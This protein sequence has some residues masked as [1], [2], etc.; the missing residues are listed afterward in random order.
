MGKMSFYKVPL[1]LDKKQDT[2]ASDQKLSTLSQRLS[3]VNMA[4]IDSFEKDAVTAW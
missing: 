2:E 4:G 1:G 3:R